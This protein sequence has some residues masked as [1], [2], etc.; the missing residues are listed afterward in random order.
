M[1]LRDLDRAV[2]C[3]LRTVAKDNSIRLKDIME[4]RTVA[5]T[6]H[7]GETLYYLPMLKVW[8]AVKKARKEVK[9]GS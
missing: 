8:C 1:V 3:E 6:A 7:E 5:I 2:L 9:H 4:W